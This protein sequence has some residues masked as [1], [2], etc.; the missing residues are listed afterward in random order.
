[1]PSR[2]A[3]IPKPPVLPHDKWY[4]DVGKYYLL[5]KPEREETTNKVLKYMRAALCTLT[6]RT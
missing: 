1:M 5:T 3:P 4:R 6:K 2:T